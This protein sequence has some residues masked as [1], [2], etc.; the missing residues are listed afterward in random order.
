MHNRKIS[1]AQGLFS[2][3]RVSK[4][5]CMDI[6]QANT[7]VGRSHRRDNRAT[8]LV[9][10]MLGLGISGRQGRRAKREGPGT[11][12]KGQAARVVNNALISN[13]CTVILKV[14]TLHNPAHL[15]PESD[16]SGYLKHKT[17]HL[18][19]ESKLQA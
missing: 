4:W 17:R 10:L 1:K 5:L 9:V 18:R 19:K 2:E 8:I 3:L 15:L 12:K 7:A 6:E 11:G 14:L 13:H 16:M